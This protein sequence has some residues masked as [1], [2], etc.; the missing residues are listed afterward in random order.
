M[1][2]IL[3]VIDNF[4][5]TN[6]VEDLA[7]VPGKVLDEFGAEVRRF[8]EAYEPPLLD[9][10]L[11]PTY[12]GGWPSANFWNSLN[13]VLVMS[14]LL[15]SGQ[16]LTKDP[17]ADWFSDEQYQRPHR[18]AARPGYLDPDTRQPNIA[19]TRAFLMHVI[20]ALLA[21]RPLIEKQ[22]LVLVP[23]HRV[24]F[25]HASAI[26]TLEQ[27]LT[28]R[29]AVDSE[30][31]TSTFAPNELSVEDNVR[32]LFVFA[33]GDREAQ[34]RKSISDSLRYFAGEYLLAELYGA[35]YTA[36]FRYEQHVC[37]EGLEKVLFGTKSERVIHAVLNSRL[38][39]FSRLT[40]SR[41]AEI[42]DDEYFGEFR[43]DLYQFYGHLRAEATPEEVAEAEG[44]LV[45]PIVE[46]IEKEAKQGVIGRLGLTLTG[47]TVRIGA[48]LL[49]PPIGTAVAGVGELLGVAESRRS[50]S[51]RDAVRVWAK[52]VDHGREVQQELKD[53]RPMEGQNL[54]GA[55]YWGIPSA[56]G[57]SIVVTRGLLLAHSLPG[58]H[59]VKRAGTG[60]DRNRN[61]LCPCGSGLKFKLCCRGIGR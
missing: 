22:I 21:M 35:T 50:R 23:S 28:D 5:A 45:R 8:A 7:T 59:Q 13:G 51:Q 52:L 1:V 30:R 33:G 58:P 56:S 4:F 49:P 40:P 15:Y 47:A 32:G 16:V 36:P 19:G 38:P 17:L 6:R 14:T 42:R 61:A 24:V 12:L 37:T 46:R 25:Q 9:Q 11:Y 57:M 18:M 44:A 27:R 26:D 54:A 41:I 34:I 29:I 2:T 60:S 48:T 39:M 31:F 53:A 20:P 3:D 10:G 43:G 55:D